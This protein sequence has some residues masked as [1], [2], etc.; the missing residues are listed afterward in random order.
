MSLPSF[1]IGVL[2]WS[3][4]E[5]ELERILAEY[6]LI[7]SK[8]LGDTS[9][10]DLQGERA[11]VLSGVHAWLS[12]HVESLVSYINDVLPSLP[13]FD[14][15]SPAPDV[16]AAIESVEAS[17][18][19]TERLVQYAWRAQRDVYPYDP[20]GEPGNVH[21]P[22]AISRSVRDVHDR[23]IA[24]LN[25]LRKVSAP[26]RSCSSDPC[27]PEP[28]SP[29]S[30][31]DIK[32]LLRWSAKIRLQEA[33]R[34]DPA[35]IVVV[36]DITYTTVVHYAAEAGDLTVLEA[37]TVLQAP[38]TASWSNLRGDT[39][40]VMAARA[41]QVEAIQFL[42]AH[43]DYFGTLESLPAAIFAAAYTKNEAVLATL[44]SNVR[45]LRTHISTLLQSA[46]FYGHLSV[47]RALVEDPEIRPDLDARGSYGFCPL[48]LA[49]LNGHVAIIELLLA[50]GANQATLSLSKVSPLDVA[51]YIGYRECVAEFMSSG[52]SNDSAVEGS[53]NWR[54]CRPP[55]HKRPRHVTFG[56]EIIP[57]NST[58]YVTPGTN[59]RRQVARDNVRALVLDRDAVHRL[60]DSRNLPRS[61]QLLLMI[62]ADNETKETSKG[63]WVLDA[64]HLQAP[65]RDWIPPAYFHTVH[66]QDLIIRASLITLMDYLNLSSS[67]PSS[68]SLAGDEPKLDVYHYHRVPVKG[69]A[70]GILALA[71]VLFQIP[72][73]L[74]PRNISRHQSSPSIITAHNNGSV[75]VQKPL[76]DKL[77]GQPVGR[78]NMEI[79]V[80]RPY[81]RVQKYPNG[82]IDP[83]ILD[84]P[85]WV[86]PKARWELDGTTMLYGHR[87]SGMNQRITNAGGQLQ[88]GENTTLSMIHAVRFGAAFV[89]FDVQLTR[90][91]VPV[92]YHDW[93]VSET[94][95]D[96]VHISSLYLDQFMALNS[97]RPFSA[98]REHAINN[99]HDRNSSY[100]LGADDSVIRRNSQQQQQQQQKQQNVRPK[101][102]S[103][104]RGPAV[105]AAPTSQRSSAS[106]GGNIVLQQTSPHMVKS[107]TT[108]CASDSK[109]GGDTALAADTTTLDTGVA[110]FNSTS[111]GVKVQLSPESH[112]HRSVGDMKHP[113]VMSTAREARYKGNNSIDTIQGPFATL[114]EIFKSVPEH[115]GFDIEIKYPMQ[116]EADEAEIWANFELNWFLDR[117]LDVVFAKVRP[118]S[119]ISSSPLSSATGLSLTL[120]TYSRPIIFTS[121]HPDVCL[122]LAHK[123]GTTFPVLFL[124]DAGISEM[125]DRRC[126]GLRAAA[127]FAEWARLGGCVSEVT[128]IYEAPR[129]VS[130]VQQHGLA[131]CTYGKLNNKAEVVKL[132]QRIGVD[133][134][135][136]DSVKAM[137]KVLDTEDQDNDDNDTL[138]TSA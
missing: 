61:T 74:A 125:S 6:H 132:Q 126:N 121:F 133:S 4:F 62:T 107:A 37:A 5:I 43:P 104:S 98:V 14:S 92:I 47:L 42:L 83:Q 39:P 82:G 79:L 127:I 31:R 128:P 23:L 117:I 110:V 25:S 21:L 123:L 122:L 10:T 58:V 111:G 96:A 53:T 85:E 131:M 91:S 135:I 54:I 77:T 44:L 15:N 97:K 34:I 36:P 28:L 112:R 70:H 2:G 66:P 118:K 68:P 29:P 71:D 113:P 64:E 130:L 108:S 78:L 56:H 81:Y 13:P 89:E 67:P 50:H 137:R 1:D 109:H 87:G 17:L 72:S 101:S 106:G 32:Q 86:L 8:G 40:L 27:Q 38:S 88:L 16:L 93:N 75:A 46:C 115:V 26:R 95:L 60:L 80:A 114:S 45:L 99:R 18:L 41:G 7:F 33:C 69:S 48:H 30:R 49:A 116:D 57:T 22:D 12:T 20:K 73:S 24:V 102:S 94:G 119:L 105:S 35:D 134:V 9:D 138:T 3:F 52:G 19:W 90:D 51:A 124:T 120:S 129:V 55:W 100:R 103:F 65:H 84:I 59:D 136:V 63:P 76:C 11:K